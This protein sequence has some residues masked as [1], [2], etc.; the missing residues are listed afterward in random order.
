MSR[1][2]NKVDNAHVQHIY[3]KVDGTVITNH[4]EVVNEISNCKDD[5]CPYPYTVNIPMQI[6]HYDRTGI[7]CQG[8]S[9]PTDYGDSRYIVTDWVPDYVAG[10]SITH[11]VFAMPTAGAD[12]LKVLALT[13]PNRGSGVDI[14]EDII[15]GLSGLPVKIKRTGDSIKDA[16]DAHL[17]WSFG[18]EPLLEDILKLAEFQKE[19]ERR[20]KEFNSLFKKG[21]LRRRIDLGSYSAQGTGGIK[22]YNSNYFNLNGEHRY[23]STVKRWGV[24]RWRPYGWSLLELPED[25]MRAK[26]IRLLYGLDLSPDAIWRKIP[27]SWLINWFSTVGQWMSANKNNFPVLPGPVCI[28]DHTITQFSLRITSQSS[29][30]KVNGRNWGRETKQRTV[31]LPG[32][33]PVSFFR[34]G[35]DFGLGKSSILGSLAISRLG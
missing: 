30:I 21:G 24:V 14:G 7:I 26:L 6:D 8:D 12:A 19:F 5:T 28:M 13:N 23:I 1:S 10:S 34:P 27:W 2:R 25:E 35:S 29:W 20:L 9:N 11:P 16:A 3:R 32:D 4:D 31:V 15:E 17:W 33:I 18:Y 22:A